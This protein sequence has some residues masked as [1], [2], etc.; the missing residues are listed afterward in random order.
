M[1]AVNGDTLLIGIAS[2][3]VAIAGFSGIAA[4]MRESSGNWT[5]LHRLRVRVIVSTGLSVA[6]ES[7]LPLILAATLDDPPTAF[8]L[9]SLA[10]AAFLLII[11]VGRLRERAKAGPPTGATGMVFLVTVGAIVLFVL[12]SVVWRSLGPY[13]A[14]LCLH[15][16]GGAI[17]FYTT[18]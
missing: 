2:G 6:F 17:S 3:A 8:A 10:A 11:T 1:P 5:P 18:I 7:F 15:L 12:D 13:S 9:A 4:A 16:A 14:A